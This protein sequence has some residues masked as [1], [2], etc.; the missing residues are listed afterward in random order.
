MK[1][2]FHFFFFF[3]I[4]ILLNYSSS[5]IFINPMG[6]DSGPTIITRQTIRVRSNDGTPVTITKI[7]IH[8]GRNIN[9]G[10]DRLTPFDLMRIAD[11]RMND[12]FEALISRHLQLFNAIER[13]EE[14]EREKE[15]ENNKNESKQFILF[16]LNNFNDSDKNKN[17]NVITIYTSPNYKRNYFN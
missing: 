15:K 1:N 7:N 8:S 17:N 2:T 12:F 16:N 5:Q 9:G 13:E 4:I 11:S 6:D 3:L 14:K 10:D